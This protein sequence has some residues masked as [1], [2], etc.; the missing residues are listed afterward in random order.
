LPVPP[1]RAVES[2][3]NTCKKYFTCDRLRM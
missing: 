3:I 1:R 2:G